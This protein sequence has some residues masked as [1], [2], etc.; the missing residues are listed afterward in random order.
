MVIDPKQQEIEAH[1]NALNA[2][3]QDPAL[4]EF[5]NVMKSKTQTKTWT[6]DDVVASSAT[7]DSA[8]VIP[9]LPNA[10]AD[11]DDDLYDDLPGKNIDPTGNITSD[12]LNDDQTSPE[13]PGEISSVPIV[14]NIETE[15][16]VIT[17]A[18][19]SPEQ[20]IAET[21]RLFVRNLPFTCAEDDLKTHFEK[22]GPVSEVHISLDSNTKQSKGYAYVL[23]M[24]PQNAVDAFI[25]LDHTSF[26]GRL[27]HVIPAS[28]NLNAKKMNE[29]LI[30]DS[31][32]Y[33]TKKQAQLQA[34]AGDDTHFKSLFMSQDAVA[35][36]MAHKLDVTKGD[37]L[38]ADGSNVAVRL[39]LAETHIIQE[40][41]QYLE[42]EGVCLDAFKSQMKKERSDTVILVKNIPFNSSEAD[43]REMFS[44]YGDIIRCVLPPTRTVALVEFSSSQE[45]K[46]AFKN[47]AYRN[48]KGRPLMLEKAPVGVFV[49][50]KDY[51]T[52]AHVEDSIADEENDEN[53]STLYIKNL[54]WSTTEEALV[55]LL[56]AVIGF[57]KVSIPKKKNPRAK[58]PNGSDALLPMGFG[59]AEFADKES[60]KKALTMFQGRVIDDHA[61]RISFSDRSAIKKAATAVDY[62]FDEEEV[63][64]TGTK[65]L[66]RNVPFETNHKELVE[67]FS[68]YGQLKKLRLPK[69]MDR[70]SHRGFAF[71][72][73][74]TKQEAK[75]AYQS[76]H[77]THLY[78]RHL[79]LEWA[80]DDTSISMLREKTR[81]QFDSMVEGEMDGKRQKRVDLTQKSAMLM[82]DDLPGQ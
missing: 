12:A 32:S 65:L 7:E 33:K 9:T 60:A 61:I 77:S 41:V 37:L 24:V 43:I 10:I 26:Q 31:T 27:M 21:G 3:K 38:N 4:R 16:P 1:V 70:S 11:P 35:D 30:D 6:N 62:T 51:E 18:N 64:V 68:T 79:V 5:L 73:F 48:F 47:L 66:V 50:K 72:E 59:F 80:E 28:E 15:E 67:L 76:L 57:R 46:T 78:G 53:T 71:V 19:E 13:I 75:N 34:T 40:T 17:N 69:K 45:S 8:S 25:N 39:A 20:R 54:N 36:A 52:V 29:D 63:Q 42:K 58:Q 23:F 74:L 82:D 44:R 49:P 55:T 22:Y 14:D 81:R 56:G 2:D